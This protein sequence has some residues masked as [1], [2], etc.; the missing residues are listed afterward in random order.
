MLH[1]QD[2]GS[3]TEIMNN[4]EILEI[5]TATRRSFEDGSLDY[6]LLAER[7]QQ[8]FPKNNDPKYYAELTKTEF[9]AGCCGPASAYLR[10]EIGKGDITYGSYQNMG[11][12]VLK[13]SKKEIVDI[14]ADQFGGPA[15]YVGSL[16]YP[17][18]RY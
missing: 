11:H 16:Q 3:N 12:L 8:W 5:A 14:T 6:E 17:W 1:K 10:S 18:T 13:I 2:Y 9:P 7:F 4:Q 15:I